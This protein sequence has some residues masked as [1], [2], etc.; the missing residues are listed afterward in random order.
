M[1]CLPPTFNL[2][3]GRASM[4]H[5]LSAVDPGNLVIRE[6]VPEDAETM[7]RFLRELAEYQETT[8]YFHA[9]REDLLRDGFGPNRE[10]ETL[11]AEDGGDPVGLATFSRTYST[12]EGHAGL[13]IQDLFVAE[14][15]RGMQVG[16]HLVKEIARLA[17]ER[18][19]THL[20][21]NVVHANPARNF[22]SRVGF[23]HMDDLLT[24]RLSQDKMQALLDL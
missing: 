8:E 6:A 21:L 14:E 12:W 3:S 4:T 5:P 23:M 7:V 9:T 13:Y 18:G 16:F 2:T 19:I 10:F 17:E 11:I 15:A 22:Y 24:Y 20:Q 1:L